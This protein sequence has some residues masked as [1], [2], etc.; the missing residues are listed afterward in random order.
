MKRD[1]HV[2]PRE[3]GWAVMRE[4][5]RRASSLHPTKREAELAGRAMAKAASV[6]MVSHRRDGR[7]SDSDSYGNDP[8]P[9]RDRKR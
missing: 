1:I 8:S 4:G 5:A 2:V 9:P 6:E 7:I 3:T